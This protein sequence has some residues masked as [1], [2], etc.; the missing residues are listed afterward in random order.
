LNCRKLVTNRAASVNLNV[1]VT[2]NIGNVVNTTATINIYN[3]IK[4]YY[5]EGKDLA[6][7]PKVTSKVTSGG[8]TQLSITAGEG[9]DDWYVD[10]VS[11]S[12]ADVTAKVVEGYGIS[13]LTNDSIETT[14]TVNIKCR[15]R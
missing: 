13:L 6:S 2:D 12:S 10:S 7:N 1:E 5:V 4:N 14:I 3:P 11:S 15:N 9:T 8:E